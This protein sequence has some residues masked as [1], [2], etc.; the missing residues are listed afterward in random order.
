M[1]LGALW[2]TLGVD[3]SRLADAEKAMLSF[4]DRVR[5]MALRASAYIGGIF[6]AK[7]MYDFAAASATAAAEMEGVGAAFRRVATPGLLEDLQK[8]TSG[9]VSNL[10][11]MKSAVQAKNFQIPLDQLA[12]LLEFANKRAQDTGQSVDYLVQSIVMG[13]GRKSVMILDNLGISATQLREK[14][15]GLGDEQVTTMDYARG[16]GEIA[17][18]SLKETG[19]VIET[20]AIKTQQ[21][22]AQMKNLQE[23]V[24][25]HLN[26]A[27]NV[28]KKH[29]MELMDGLAMTFFKQDI[30]TEKA[31][32]RLEVYA[33]TLKGM[34]EQA[35]R[36]EMVKYIW[37]M[38]RNL[39]DLEKKF[40]PFKEEGQMGVLDSKKWT[41]LYV[42][43]ENEID[44]VKKLIELARQFDFSMIPGADPE[45][46]EKIDKTIGAL[47][48]MKERLEALQ[49]Q[50]GEASTEKVPVLVSQIR[51]LEEAIETY[52]EGMMLPRADEL[53]WGMEP[54]INVEK[55]KFK[56]PSI[57]NVKDLPE[58][59]TLQKELANIMRFDVALG[60]TYDAGAAVIQAYT[61][62]IQELIAEGYSP[63]DRAIKKLT[64]DLKDLTTA[65]DM[66]NSAAQRGNDLGMITASV[67]QDVGAGIAG[68]AQAWISMGDT[69]MRV[70]QEIIGKQLVAA[71]VSILQGETSKKGLGGLVTAAAGLVALS[72]LWETAKSQLSG[73][74]KMAEGGVVPP[75]YPNDTYPALLTSGE[76]VENPKK[77]GSSTAGITNNLH[78]TLDAEIT[79]RKL[80]LVLKK[81]E[82]HL[83]K[84]T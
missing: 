28:M 24:G 8:A 45:T 63:Q 54:I 78:L 21:L 70:L 48:I 30:T 81:Y 11:L 74:A 20:S 69:M 7:K 31:Q 64:E 46:P 57:T 29:L 73:A 34:D 72:A 80:Y 32:Q 38:G 33:N 12:T 53:A 84:T 66:A 25:S 42:S 23:T 59:K 13:I 17:T 4:T 65:Q 18:E 56:I 22:N 83:T 68:N 77:L 5:G 61:N 3:A 82:Q 75:G 37:N 6:A 14:F 58:M 1:N 15:K 50:L 60:D 27:L 35:A 26:P 52:K 41:E 49:K 71:F 2:A 62:T 76:I 55:L 10:E 67:L 44:V 19:G 39:E 9:T 47:N 79:G 36:E 43:Q 40:A 51:D 16:V